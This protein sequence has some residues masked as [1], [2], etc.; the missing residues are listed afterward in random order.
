MKLAVLMLAVVLGMQE[1]PVVL[2]L[3]VK[4]RRDDQLV[5][6]GYGAEQVVLGI[7]L[8]E[9]GAQFKK[10]DY[11]V[12]IPGKMNNFLKHVLRSPVYNKINFESMLFFNKRNFVLLMNKG[13]VVSVLSMNVQRV[14][15]DSVDIHNGVRNFLKSYRSYKFN[16]SRFGQNTM[17]H[18]NRLGIGFVDDGNDDDI[19]MFYIFNKIK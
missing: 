10:D 13:V 1:S 8:G 5:V 7:S 11:K 9:V 12:V 16:K 6:P 4:I 14:T 3:K 18:C 17:Y 19:D 15:I 2:G